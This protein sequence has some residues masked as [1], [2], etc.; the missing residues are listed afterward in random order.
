MGRYEA[1]QKAREE[2]GDCSINYN[3]TEDNFYK[4]LNAKNLPKIIEALED[5]GI[6]LRV[7]NGTL[8]LSVFPEKYIKIKDRH[9]GKRKKIAWD[10]EAHDVFRYSDIV[11]F[12]QTMKDPDVAVKIGMPIA[13]FYR[14]KKVLKESEYYR[15]LDRNRLEDKEYL[16]SMDGNRTF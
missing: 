9:A 2:F 12:M 14:H 15:S 13:T 16:E 1:E 8:R 11:R 3:I 5:V 4:N 10:E 6:R 7:D